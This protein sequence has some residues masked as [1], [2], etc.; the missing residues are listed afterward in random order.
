MPHPGKTINDHNYCVSLSL[1]PFLFQMLSLVLLSKGHNTCKLKNKRPHAMHIFY[2]CANPNQHTF[3]DYF[4][5][6]QENICSD[7]E[8]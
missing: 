6:N 3:I 1:L 2:I 5:I 8:I 4:F 7:R